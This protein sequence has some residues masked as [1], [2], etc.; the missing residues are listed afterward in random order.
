MHN[1]NHTLELKTANNYEI[2]K[3]LSLITSWRTGS[4]VPH[5]I[6][7][8]FT[9]QQQEII[10]SVPCHQKSENDFYF[11]EKDRK[12]DGGCFYD[13]ANVKIRTERKTNPT[14]APTRNDVL[15]K[16]VTM[17]P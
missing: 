4:H 10:S 12:M 1:Q 8:L 7:R 2:D 14:Q 3:I 16:A 15:L 6:S 17:A 5:Q 11:L 9:V 13:T